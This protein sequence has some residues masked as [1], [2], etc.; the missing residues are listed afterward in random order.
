MEEVEISNIW[1]GSLRFMRFLIL[2][3]DFNV[4]SGLNNKDYIKGRI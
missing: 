1:Q 4:L 3:K 2:F